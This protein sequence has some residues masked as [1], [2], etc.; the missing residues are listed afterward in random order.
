MIQMHQKPQWNPWKLGWYIV[1]MSH[2]SNI[3][4]IKNSTRTKIVFDQQYDYLWRIE[5]LY[6]CSLQNIIEL[7]HR[8]KKQNI[9]KR[10]ISQH[11]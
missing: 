8:Y 9:T 11:I 4:I 6:K 1:G 10:C 5:E 3:I 7:F 2:E